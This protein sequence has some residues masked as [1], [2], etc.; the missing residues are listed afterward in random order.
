[1][2]ADVGTISADGILSLAY[3]FR[4]SKALLAAVELEVFTVLGDATLPASTLAERTGVA[5][6]GATDFFD[7]LVALGMLE[8]YTKGGYSNT[9]QSAHFLNRTRPN[10]IGGLLDH[11]NHREYEMWAALSSTLRS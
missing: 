1:M 3:A 10:Y 6:R 8:R 2:P 11:L 7:A 5:E 9:V 4:G